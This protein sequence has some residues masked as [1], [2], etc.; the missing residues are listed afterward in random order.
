[1]IDKIY[2]QNRGE[3]SRIPK[4]V[5][6]FLLLF[7]LTIAQ[8]MQAQN[9]R[10]DIWYFGSYA[11]LDFSTSPPTPLYDGQLQTSE[12][13]ATICDE[14]G[15]L[16]FY[17][18]GRKV[19]NANHEIMPNGDG[20]LGSSS[21]SQSGV[22]VPFPGNEN[23]YY[24]FTVAHQGGSDGLCYNLID[25]TLAEGMG[26]ILPGKKNIKLHDPSTEK[27]T[28]VR[29]ANN[30]DIWVISHDW[31]S[32][33]FRTFLVDENGINTTPIIQSIGCMHTGPTSYTIGVLKAS[34]DGKKLALSIMYENLIEM[35]DFDNA[36]AVISN[37]IPTVQLYNQAYG[38]EFSPDNTKLYF[39]EVDYKQLFQID[40]TELVPGEEY[41][42]A[43]PISMTTSK[44]GSLQ[45]GPDGIIYCSGEG[46]Q[47]MDAILNP[48]GKGQD[49]IFQKEHT[50][51]GSNCTF[52]LP[53]Y[54]QSYFEPNTINAENNCFG[55]ATNFSVENT[56]YVDSVLW[57]FYD[58]PNTLLGTS[59][60][61]NPEYIFPHTGSFS[62]KVILFK[63]H[64]NDT[65]SKIINIVSP[66]QPNLGND[67]LFCFTP[68]SLILKPNCVFDNIIWSTGQSGIEEITV[69]D[70]GQYWVEVSQEG[71][72][73]LDTIYVGLSPLP[74]L[75]ESALLITNTNCGTATGSISGLH[76][77]GADPFVFSWIDALGDTIS[78]ELDVLD[79]AAGTYTLLAKD[80]Y[81]C[82]NILNSYTIEDDG[83]MLIDSVQF[84][85]DHCL[86]N[87]GSISI[88]VPQGG[89]GQISYSIDGGLNYFLNDGIFDALAAGE[90][91]VM[92]KDE[93]DCTGIYENNPI[94][95]QNISSLEITQS[96]ATPETDYLSDGQIEIE[97]FSTGNALFYS[98]DAG[99]NFQMDNGL[100]GGL[101]SGLYPC[102]VKD[103]FMCDSAFE[104]FVP[105]AF[106]N[107]L[108]AIAGN[109]ATCIGN[110]AVS[111]LVL[112]NFNAVYRFEV[113]L[114]YNFDIVK[115]DGYINLNS[116]LEA[117]F[118]ASVNPILGEINIIWQGD[119]AITLPESSK[120]VE[121]V[122]S[123][124]EEGLSPVNWQADPGESQFFNLDMQEITVQYQLGSVRVYTRPEITMASEL[125]ICEGEGFSIEANVSGGSGDK[126][127][128]WTGPNGFTSDQAKI[129]ILNVLPENSGIYQLRV[130]DTL[131][132]DESSQFEL[133]VDQLPII[134]F[135]GQDTIFAEPGYELNAGSGYMGYLWNTGATN[136]YILIDS[137]GE[138]F[139]RVTSHEGCTQSDTVQ[140]RWGN[141]AFFLPNAFTPNG[142]GLNDDFGPIT[143]FEKIKDFHMAIY[144]RWG[145]LVFETNNETLGWNGRLKGKTCQAGVYIYQINFLE[146]GSNAT[147]KTIRGTV[148]LVR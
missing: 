144:S 120:M 38:L 143:V 2:Q 6:L 51:V 27:I 59:N 60:L 119:A 40:L 107:T 100:F 111:P 109:G 45:L 134:A 43:F 98:I 118:Q 81:G 41:S 42:T 84:T 101:S 130:E 108:E 57:S 114:K 94:V 72:S 117:G 123:G 141:G 10:A 88:F 85:N 21:S 115:C 26:D 110:A 131:K 48:N 99:N 68:L 93:N 56:A 79:L 19:W 61:L 62:V 65:L 138:Y 124:I 92:V 116:E 24:L 30:L 148:V 74:I 87:M 46:M 95:L 96:I 44:V 12:G 4:L 140:I 20:L 70:T 36:T 14:E 71:C 137:I 47:T 28:A 125:S 55:E 23:L 1:M 76:V 146:Q 31:G 64:F 73:N 8:T 83:N 50:Y 58:F 112:N 78:H 49:C 13:C 75:D 102:V 82:L 35:F 69:V 132:C 16:L 80:A 3:Q 9:G 53:N 22:I 103:D 136:E 127:F 67:T 86:Q 128:L 34:H 105:R 133:V 39:S 142:D 15:N 97:A 135:A 25:M 77:I 63:E 90:Y 11:G 32:D 54:I 113:E 121:L 126:T 122:F 129:E 18:E 145:E 147:A 5:L 91:P 89:N 104:V 66:P 33:A 106:S 29:H 7:G 17:T 139:V 37:Y 52:G